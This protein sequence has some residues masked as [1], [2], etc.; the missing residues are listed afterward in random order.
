MA[1][2]L[3]KAVGMAAVLVTCLAAAF[4]V[5]PTSAW[6]MPAAALGLHAVLKSN[7]DDDDE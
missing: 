3:A 2:N 6:W 4:L 5:L 7:D 1:I